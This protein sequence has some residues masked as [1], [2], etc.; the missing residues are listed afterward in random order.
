MYSMAS[1]RTLSAMHI[2]TQTD[3]DSHA[4]T[5]SFGPGAF[6]VET[7]QYTVDVA[8]FLASLGQ[9][10]CVPIVTVA[11]AYDD[12]VSHETFILVFYQ[13][14]YFD[15]L[16]SN[17]LCPNQLR[18]A[19]HVV[20][21]TPL[22][23]LDEQQ[24]SPHSHAIVCQDPFLLIPLSLDGVASTFSTRCP[25]ADEFHDPD[26]IHIEMTPRTPWRPHDTLFSEQEL[27]L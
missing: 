15:T 7:T 11:L 8:P 27:T 1:Y 22:C 6:I 5:C 16:Q 10:N 13:S 9:V 4:D 2:F 17:L 18:A 14:L 3:L 26:L 19:G 20:N 24:R 25:S 23:F 12:P 21:E